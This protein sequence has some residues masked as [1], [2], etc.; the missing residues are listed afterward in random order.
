[1]GAAELSR[2]LAREVGR[3]WGL[4][5]N[6][7]APRNYVEGVRE[8]V[9]KELIEAMLQ[10]GMLEL[11]EVDITDIPNNLN[12]KKLNRYRMAT[13]AVLNE[14]GDEIGRQTLIAPDAPIRQFPTA[15]EKAVL[16]QSEE[17][18]YIGQAPTEVAKTQLRNGNV[19]N[20][21]E[22]IA[23]IK[24]QQEVPHQWNV[25]FVDM[26]EDMGIEM[27]LRL[28]GGGNLEA[29]P[30]N[31]NHKRTLAGRN[32]TISSAFS[33]I[34]SM[35][36]ESQNYASLNNQELADVPVFFAY[37]DTVVNRAQMLGKDNPQSNKLM[38]EAILPTWQVMD[39]TDG[40]QRDLFMMGLA[41]ALGIKVHTQ[42]KAKSLAQVRDKL[43]GMDF[44]RS[45]LLGSSPD[46]FSDTVIDRMKAEGINSIAGLHA[47]M[48]Y[49]RFMD[50]ATDKTQF[51]TS[52]Y[53]EA[54][55]VTNGVV[56]AIALFS[57]DEIT[58]DQLDSLAR[59]G[60]EVGEKAM[61][62]AEIRKRFAD[63]AED[64]YG[65]AGTKTTEHV[66][67]LRRE[68]A[69]DPTIMGQMNAVRDVLAEFLSDI[70]TDGGEEITVK[71]GAV[72]NP[73]TITVYGS[74]ANGI[75]NNLTSEVI[76]RIYERL[77]LAAQ[78]VAE[79]PTLTEA[80]AFYGG[81]A[82]TAQI[83]FDL[84]MENLSLLMGNSMGTSKEGLWVN[85]EV[86]G[87]ANTFRDFIKFTFPK[88]AVERMQANILHSF[89]T[90]MVAG[91]SDTVG[92]GLMTN[93]NLIKTQVQSWSLLGKFAYQLAYDKAL[94]EKGYT[95]KNDLLTR[96][97]E[98]AVLQ[99]V[100]NQLPYFQ[101]G[102]QNFLFGMKQAMD[103]RSEFASSL[104]DGLGTPAFG[105]TPDDAGVAGIPGLT[106]GSG[107][108]Q[109]ILN[110]VND[111]AMPEKFL[112]IFDGVHSSVLDMEQMGRVTNK[113]VFDAWQRN[114]MG[115]L[116]KAFSKFVD[117]ADLSYLNEDQ[118]KLMTRSL[119]PSTEWSDAKSSAQIIARM[120]V[121]AAQGLAAA[122]GVDE[123]HAVMAQVQS[124]VDQM[125]GAASP[126]AVTGVVLT[127]SSNQKAQ[128]ME[129][130]RKAPPVIQEERAAEAV[131][132]RVVT[133]SLMGKA[134]EKQI[135]KMTNDRMERALLRDVVRSGRVDDYAIFTG[136]RQ[137]ILTLA[138]EAGISIPADRNGFMGF[139]VP[140]S[141]S[142]YVVDGNMETMIHELIHA[143]TY[144]TVAAY[145]AGETLDAATTLAVQNLEGLM[146]QFKNEDFGNEAQQNALD[147]IERQEAAGNTAAALNEFMAWSLANADLR[148]S[149]AAVKASPLVRMAR[150]VVSAIKSLLWGGKRSAAVKNDMFTN[151]RFNTNV[152]M[153]GMPSVAQM[154][155]DGVLYHHPAYGQDDRISQLM[156]RMTAKITDYIGNEDVER[157]VRRQKLNPA[158]ANASRVALG[159]QNAGFHMNK[160]QQMAFIRM[161]AI[162]ATD[163]QLDGNAMQ[164]MQDMFTHVSNNLAVQDFLKN[165]DIND[166]ADNYQAQLKFNVLEGQFSNRRD[167]YGRSFVLPGFIALAAVNDEFRAI[168]SKMEMPKA[169]YAAWNSVDNILDNIGDMS[170]DAMGR[171]V[172]GQR[173]SKITEAMDGM[174]QQMLD[175]AEDSRMYIEKFTNPIGDGVDKL[176]QVVIDAAISLGNATQ[177]NVDRVR[178][179]NPNPDTGGKI[180]I[181]VAESLNTAAQMLNEDNG[182]EAATRLMSV[183]NR[184][185]VWRPVYELF[186][187][188]VG[189]T[190]ENANVYDLIKQA[191]AWVNGIR[192]Q[193]RE[194]LPLILNN[195]FSR[196]LTDREQTN[197]HRGLGQT[198]LASLLSSNTVDQ[199]LNLLADKPS[200]DVEVL[201][202]R[203]LIDTLSPQN[204]SL[205][206]QK[207][208]QL[209]DYMIDKK[210]SKGLLRNADAIA[211]LLGENVQ[212]TVTTPQMVEAIDHL[213]TLLAIDKLSIGERLSLTSLVQKEAEGMGFML[214]FI[215]GQDDIDNQK[216]SG[217]ARFQR[218]KG[219]MPSDT[220]QGTSFIV[221]SDDNADHLLDRGYTRLGAYTGS[222]MDPTKAGMSYWYAPVSGR[223][224]FAQGIMQN[225]QQ[226]V[227]G[228]DKSTGFSTHMTAGQ[229]TD[230]NLVRRIANRK[231]VETGDFLMPLYN[232]DGTLYG[233]ERPI[234][235]KMLVHQ[236]R[237]TNMANMMGVRSGRQSEE[238]NSFELNK[239]LIDRLRDMYEA[240][241]KR[242]RD[243][244]YVNLS[245]SKDP[246][247]M[248]AVGIFSNET[249]DYIEA[250]FPEGFYVRK[251]MIDD[252]VGYRVA[253]IGDAWTGTSR[254]SPKA[255]EM[256]KNS[257]RLMFG[258]NAYRYAVTSERLLQNVIQDARTTIVIKSIVV[259][260][261]NAASNVL[262]LIGRG[263][264]FTKIS[265]EIPKKIAEIDSWHK[266]RIRQ[267]EAEAE[268]LATDNAIEKRRLQA[269]IRS[270][271][272]SHQRLSIW[273][274]LQA[275]EFSSISDA[276]SREDVLLTEGKLNAYIENAV[277]RLPK[278][279]RTAGKY[280]IM[281]KDTALFRAMQKATE[282]GDF[283]AKSILYD[284]IIS[285]QG[286]SSQEALGMVG[287]EFVNYDRLP[288]RDR[289]YMESVGLMWFWNFKVRSAKVA[290]SMVRNNPVHSLIAMALP[291]PVS[292]MGLPLED[293]L[294]ASLFD[295]RLT[296][297]F[298]YDML[299]RAPGL[300]P[301]G[302]L[303]F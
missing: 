20:T 152:V 43:A 89:V 221:A 32:L 299:F 115:E 161:V 284:D 243:N 273:P 119:F 2:S 294:W 269:E 228:V 200:R 96:A 184:T 222:S 232:S 116:A 102:Q 234:D 74:S 252:A 68:Y 45:I 108:G 24:K 220:A 180:A 209:A 75:A 99:S 90:P 167:A 94:A 156:N 56:N 239:A 249:R 117:Q 214:S 86:N 296:H 18:T 188:L 278:S 276:G 293:N 291:T 7:N 9:A 19:E 236:E 177:A 15:I 241:K 105:F 251:D 165:P 262:Q 88:A 256:V 143:A 300:L 219:Y 187:D 212:G 59:G 70:K 72:K 163:A 203:R 263:V 28:F 303:L 277:D 27:V 113:A 267:I 137:E 136:S 140:G 179:N 230:P 130:M 49:A 207:A 48:E 62:L 78:R 199:A 12:T 144:E 247:H 91:I 109:T 71:R 193:Y 23:S 238:A 132:V 103:T 195:K 185:G 292:G 47:V 153:R 208:E 42:D 123:R 266:S 148:A 265:K 11:V 259:P 268:L 204:A 261:A 270:I 111:P 181:K 218:W 98:E 118:R 133:P 174:I 149:E 52:I 3:F 154:A 6:S 53:F 168:L 55:G 253:S 38:R 120:K 83:K 81:D 157:I 84:L 176:N 287:E 57:S 205:L 246:I 274:L 69:D 26:I 244:E 297:S 142:I 114:P 301:M 178:E 40:A 213:V 240:D 248:D 197:L 201:R 302:H 288:G 34:Q 171:R 237:D 211:N 127:G 79:E 33:T 139:T 46:R 281:S 194:Q 229:I 233:Y 196:E 97:E 54:D 126:H 272:D 290:L 250:R 60:Y 125:A 192:Q 170:I 85:E 162:L 82:E 242:G 87:K 169:K 1:M 25:P 134:L 155:T 29:Q 37:N 189:R 77:S 285:R 275:G 67:S 146:E 216:A 164:R 61:P 106:I 112:Q 93:L 50:E 122:E 14:K 65:L 121:L 100:W 217:N 186:R 16:T 159:F 135:A 80:Q 150:K 231:G 245:K 182:R 191:R 260:M 295:G 13:A 17:V 257:L 124:S 283:V 4:Q 92:E 63:G 44:T 151:I 128:A 254:W 198:G 95:S 225:V 104:T 166:P 36:A 224:G 35:I 271:S 226:T 110:A 10:E 172:G 30:F 145:Y 41:Q 202:L 160:Q 190:S 138:A 101:T 76:S 206:N 210:L 129:M 223:A 158:L 289:A 258:D 279:V 73:L 131:P 21:P 31:Q 183:A 64:L 175:T 282:Y 22:Q 58:G 107:D 235:P 66:A 280:A 8:G 39:L 255:Q 215:Q 286:K 147:E 173:G 298:G 51:R 227:G 264:P 5:D 141:K